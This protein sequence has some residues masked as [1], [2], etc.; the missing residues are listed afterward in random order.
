MYVCMYVCKR[1]E[2]MERK[3]GAKHLLSTLYTYTYIFIHLHL[4]TYLHTHSRSA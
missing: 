2:Y 3:G 1:A 4:H